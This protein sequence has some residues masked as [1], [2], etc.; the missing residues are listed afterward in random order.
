MSKVQLGDI[1][2]KNIRFRYATRVE[3]FDAF[4]A[5][6]QQGK[7]TAIVGESGSGKSTLVSLL[8]KIYPLQVGS[9]HIG[10]QNLAYV[11]P[12]ILR[13]LIRVVPQK[14]DLFAG[15]VIDNI[16][17]GEFAPNMERIINICTSIGILSFIESLPDGFYTYL[18]EHG[19]SLSGG[20]QQR[21]SISRA[22]YHDPEILVFDEATSSLD[23]Q[24]EQFIQNTI[25]GL[26]DENKTIIIIAHRLSTGVH[27]DE[28]ML[29]ENGQIAESGTHHELFSLKGN[30]ILCG[31]NNCLVLMGINPPQLLYPWLRQL[32]LLPVVSLSYAQKI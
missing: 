20:Q 15:N 9:I 5:R 6:F 22:L 13:E 7:I 12:N 31:N 4:S 26:R 17:D 2:F 8:Q 32:L 16:T 11:A 1:V 14:I 10:E 28:V 30:T 21:I 18:G 24:S 25:Q 27:A 19:A 3:V 29:F 23:S